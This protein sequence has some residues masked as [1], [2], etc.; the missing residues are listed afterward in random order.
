MSFFEYIPLLSPLIF[1]GILLLSLLQFANVRKNM[2][3]QSEQQIYTKVIEARLKLEN[4]DTFTNMAMQSPMF[5]KRFS[6]V[7]TPEEYYVSVAFL[8]LFEFMFRLHKTKTIDPLLWQRWNKLVHIFLTIPKFKRV[9]EETKSS[10]T[11][12][13][14]EFFDSLQDLEE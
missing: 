5:T 11:V 1:A 4:T 8:D 13:F 2:R 3:I 9:W 7:D 6:I 14:I 12:E 10:H